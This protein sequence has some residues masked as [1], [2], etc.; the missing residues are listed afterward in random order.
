MSSSAENTTV[1]PDRGSWKNVSSSTSSALSVW[2]MKTSSTCVYLRVR[3]RY[4]SVKKRLARS[5]LFSSIEDD[6]S[7]RQNIAARAT[8]SGRSTR[9][10]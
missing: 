3:N 9:L 10:R 2:R 1:P 8:G 6:T 5:F 4:S 7:I